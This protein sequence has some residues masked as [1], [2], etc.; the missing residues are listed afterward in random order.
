M[1]HTAAEGI[2]QS[3]KKPSHTRGFKLLNDTENI[4]LWS[5]PWTLEVMPGPAQNPVGYPGV[6][7]LTFVG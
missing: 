1:N 2:N 7:K 6:G 4:H 3:M 5:D